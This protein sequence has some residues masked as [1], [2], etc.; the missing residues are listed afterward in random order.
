MCCNQNTAISATSFYESCPCPLPKPHPSSKLTG[1]FPEGIDS[2]DMDN[3]QLCVT[4]V[5]RPLNCNS[6]FKG[7]IVLQLYSIPVAARSAASAKNVGSY[8]QRHSKG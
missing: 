5:E 2:F 3:L 4:C 8:T 1:L 7:N 6:N